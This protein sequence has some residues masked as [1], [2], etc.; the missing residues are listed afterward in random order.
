MNGDTDVLI[1]LVSSLLPQHTYTQ[2]VIL[3]ALIQS[4]GD[5]EAAIQ[6]LQSKTPN[7]KRNQGSLDNWLNRPAK[8]LSIR[9]SSPA[10]TSIIKPYVPTVASS[11]MSSVESILRQPPSDTPSVPRRLPP[12][13]LSTPALVA[14][15]T[16]CTLHLSVLPPELA[17]KL[18]YTMLDESKKWKRNKWWIADKVVESPHLTSFYVRK[19]DGLDENEAWQEAAQYWCVI[20]IHTISWTD[21]LSISLLC[22]YNGRAA[23][24]PPKFPSEME[25]AC[26]IVERIVNREMRKRQR[27]KLEWN[28]G[29]TGDT[30]PLWRANVAASNC[31]QGGKESVGFHCDQLTYLGPYPTIASLSLGKYLYIFCSK[32]N[33]S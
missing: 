26:E 30:D 11:S 24:P 16:P 21:M 14:E 23:N 22:R 25:E 8:K 1:A 28:S 19:T 4:N 5:V 2:D 31:Y 27:F 18:F 13:I 7:K 3:D 9:R 6:A 33:N 32:T 29:A 17:C 15:H 10:P 20:T 12:L